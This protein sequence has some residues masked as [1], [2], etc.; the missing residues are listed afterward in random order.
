MEDLITTMKAIAGATGAHHYPFDQMDY[1]DA[2]NAHEDGACK[3]VVASFFKLGADGV[4]FAERATNKD[5][6]KDTWKEIVKN[7][8]IYLS[9]FNPTDF[10][11]DEIYYIGGV[12]YRESEESVWKLVDISAKDGCTGIDKIA[13][14][15]SKEMGLYE[16][17][18][19]GHVMGVINFPGQEARFVDPNSGVIM[20]QKG[21]FAGAHNN[22][23]SDMS[24]K[25]RLEA[26]IKGYLSHPNVRSVYG[27]TGA[28]AYSSIKLM[29]N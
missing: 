20:Y 28:N 22:G 29:P 19:R 16:I 17:R 1:L 14:F 8:S 7:Y 12:A 2:L 6:W 3:A 18:M 21:K 4:R 26:G 25:A 13:S 24:F 9:N 15:I 10:D 5:T 27:T 23:L 11:E